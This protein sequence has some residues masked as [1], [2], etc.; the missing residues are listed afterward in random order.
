MAKGINRFLN[1]D[2]NKR[3]IHAVL[4]LL[5]KIPFGLFSQGNDES[6]GS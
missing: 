3:E 1:V 6:N 5:A 4:N 2:G